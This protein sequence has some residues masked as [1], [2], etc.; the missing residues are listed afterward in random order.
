MR[1]WVARGAEGGRRKHTAGPPTRDVWE[2]SRG[3]GVFPTSKLT[4]DGKIS[5]FVDG[6]R[7]GIRAKIVVVIVEQFLIFL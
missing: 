2:A 3:G 6:Q 1:A 5:G 7:A 4:W